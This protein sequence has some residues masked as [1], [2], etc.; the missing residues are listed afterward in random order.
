MRQFNSDTRLPVSASAAP[1][2][3]GPLRRLSQAVGGIARRLV[4]EATAIQPPLARTE[5]LEP[6]RLL[7]TLFGGETFTFEIR[8]PT[9][10]KA[11]R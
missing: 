4:G 1:G 5:L 3:S 2:A 9:R 6:R 7:T 11:A 8:S 10:F